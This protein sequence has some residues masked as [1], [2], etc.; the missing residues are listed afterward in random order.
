MYIYLLY[1]FTFY[2]TFIYIY[3]FLFV[4]FSEIYALEMYVSFV[5]MSNTANRKSLF[6][7]FLIHG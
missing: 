4:C 2:Y 3:I 7:V 1:I 5:F 6:D